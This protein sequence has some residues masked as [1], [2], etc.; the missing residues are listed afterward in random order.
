MSSFVQEF[1]KFIKRGNILDLAVGIAIGG[2]FGALVQSL[3]ADIIM[4]PVGLLLGEVDFSNLFA[5]LKAGTEPGPYLTLAQAKEVGAITINYGLFLNHLI[6]LLIIGL[7]LF[8]VVRLINRLKEPPK[9]PAPTTKE[10]P[11][12]HTNIPLPAVRCP[13]CTSQL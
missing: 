1:K 5:T 4:P 8:L 6:S 11:Y 3:V 13:N 10:C 12:C 9:A 2:A 7:S